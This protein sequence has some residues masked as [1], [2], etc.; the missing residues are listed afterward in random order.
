MFRAALTLI[1]DRREAVLKCASLHQLVE[2]FQ[3]S[4]TDSTTLKC[5]EFMQVCIGAIHVH[6][7]A[8]AFCQSLVRLSLA[9]GNHRYTLLLS[10]K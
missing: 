10:S 5:H 9:T 3:Y 2:R 6:I 7:S 8:Q 4:K 1:Q